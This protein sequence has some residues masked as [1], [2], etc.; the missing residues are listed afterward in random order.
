MVR[1]CHR[2]CEEIDFVIYSRLRIKNVAIYE[3]VKGVY[4]VNCCFVYLSIVYRLST[5]IYNNIIYRSLSSSN[6]H[7]IFR[8]LFLSGFDQRQ[9][10]HKSCNN[11]SPNC[12]QFTIPPRIY[13]ISTSRQ[14][15]IIP[16]NSTSTLSKPIEPLHPGHPTVNLGMI[17]F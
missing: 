10:Y 12:I 9:Q 7:I 11:L 8:I 3:A 6:Y 2:I 4:F 15:M 14:T 5:V 17:Q 16:L 1:T 13:Q